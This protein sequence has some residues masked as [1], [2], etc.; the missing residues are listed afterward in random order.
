MNVVKNGLS[1]QIDNKIITNTTKSECSNQKN[2]ICSTKEIILDIKKYIKNKGIDIINKDDNE[3]INLAKQEFNCDSESCILN[4]KSFINSSNKDKIEYVLNNNFKTKG[5]RN[6]TNLLSNFNIDKTLLLWGKEFDNFY[7]C[8]FSMIDFDIHPNNFSKINLFDVVNGDAYYY[9]NNNKKIQ[10]KFNCFACVLNTDVSSGRGKH[11]VCIFVDCRSKKKEDSW[12]IE[13][14]NSAGN[15]PCNSV[16]KWMESQRINLMKLNKN[17][18]TLNVSNTV[19]QYSMTECGPYSL[20]YIRSRLDGV[21]YTHFYSY[22][23][24]DNLMIEFRKHIFR[25]N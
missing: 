18:E 23:I 22:I 8:S 9:D 4:N 17:V 10:A 24:P 20:Y 19:H 12:T 11:W 7:P 13:Y 15:S 21:S 5:P 25:L 3:I 6:N 14:F 2:G 16:I 1:K